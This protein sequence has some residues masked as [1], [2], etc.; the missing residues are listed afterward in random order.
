[1]LIFVLIYLLLY[2]LCVI[3]SY[4]LS[5]SLNL[6]ITPFEQF[7]TRNFYN[8]HYRSVI[9]FPPDWMQSRSVP[10]KRLG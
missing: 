7:F 4:S 10:P 5:K 1:M 8:H 9:P 6:K 3:Q 2:T